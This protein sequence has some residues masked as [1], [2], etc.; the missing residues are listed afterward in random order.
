MKQIKIIYFLIILI[1]FT[2]CD[3]MDEYQELPTAKKG[4][5]LQ[6]DLKIYTVD[7]CEYI[8]KVVGHNDDVLT[9]KGNCKFCLQRINKNK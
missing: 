5:G 6:S 8:G 4:I 2:S 7:S 9:H 1:L 3:A